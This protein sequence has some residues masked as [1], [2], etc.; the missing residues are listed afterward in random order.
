M[1]DVCEKHRL[2]PAIAYDRCIGCELEQ[3]RAEVKWLAVE[4]ESLR[5]D[6]DERAVQ[7][8]ELLAEIQRLRDEIATLRPSG[9]SRVWDD[10]CATVQL[11]T[12][13]S[14][15]NPNLSDRV[16]AAIA[17]IERLRMLVLSA[18]DAM[19]E[20]HRTKTSKALD[21][22]TR[23][24]DMC[25]RSEL[26]DVPYVRS[27]IESETAQLRRQLKDAVEVRDQRW[28]MAKE[29]KAEADRLRAEMDRLPKTADGVPVIAGDF[30][31]AKSGEKF[32]VLNGYA[33]GIGLSE[34]Y[35][36]GIHE[37]YS[38]REAAQKDLEPGGHVSDHDLEAAGVTK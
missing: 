28:Q 4:N 38:T 18:R 1:S 3:L 33:F 20:Y 34:G 17:E 25:N 23:I 5:A 9:L 24:A 30:V 26:L 27:V 15:G 14:S 12:Q 36:Q 11:V 32:Q 7:K 13:F 16:G 6:R 21:E 31:F 29:A 8:G 2:K 10:Y 37:T 19:N 22:V 35:V